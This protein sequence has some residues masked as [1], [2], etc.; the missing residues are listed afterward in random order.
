MIDDFSYRVDTSWKNRLAAS[1]SKGDVA[2]FVDDDQPDARDFAQ[3]SVE[4]ADAMR[5][6][7]SGDPAGCWGERHAVSGLSGGDCQR[8]G[9]VGFAGAGWAEQDDV[10]GFS[11]PAA[12]FQSCDLARSTWGWAV[13]SKSV[14]VLSA[15]KPA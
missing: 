10:V 7:E 12:G 14:I 9:E 13:K 6:A 8:C 11:Q 4:S 3:F 5:F 1:V 15:G 2:D